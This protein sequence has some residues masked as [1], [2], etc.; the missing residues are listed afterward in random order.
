[1]HAWTVVEERWTQSILNLME[2]DTHTW[3]LP[4]LEE[5]RGGMV[6]FTGNWQTFINHYTRRF[7]PLD[8]AEAV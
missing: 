6:P 8:T 2:G 3:A 1:M 7:T 4:Y 5:L